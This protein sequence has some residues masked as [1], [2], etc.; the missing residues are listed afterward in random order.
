MSDAKREGTAV[1]SDAKRAKS[2][3]ISA[4]KRAVNGARSG[5]Q[6]ERYAVN[7][8]AERGR[9]QAIHSKSPILLVAQKAGPVSGKLT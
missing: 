9:R 5:P 6:G 7:N 1:T 8:E 2:A 3:A 4:A